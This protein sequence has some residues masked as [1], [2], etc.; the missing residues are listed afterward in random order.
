MAEARIGVIGGSGLYKMQGVT[1]A[2]KVKVSTPFG[3]PSDAIIL[4][5]LEGVRVAFLPRHGEGHRIGPSELPAKANIYALKSLGVERIISVSAVGS[6]REEI[7]PLDIVI[8]DQLIDATKGRASTFFTDGIVGHVSLA[9]PFCPVLSQLSFETSTQVGAEF[10]KGGTYLVVEGPQF[11]TKAEAQLY[12]SWGADIIGMTALPEAKLAREA[13]I[14]YATV[15]IVT[16]Y[17]CWHP[18]YQSVT[19]EMILANLKMGID[20]AGKILKLLLPSIPQERECACA[21]ALQYAIATDAK[22]IP[23]EKRKQL[24]LFIG[25]YLAEEKDVSQA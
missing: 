9:E 21:S 2:K 7:E 1:E 5:N 16:D 4:G 19:T 8:P 23:K 12:R 20:T 17:D 10:H 14:C 24:G 25:K 11:S 22:Y 15:A 6:L 13:E 18:S 3:E